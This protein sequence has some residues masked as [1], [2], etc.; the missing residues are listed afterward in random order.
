MR[1]LNLATHDYANFSHDNANA[2][3][4]V[5][6]D[7]VD[8]KRCPHEFNYKTES[9]IYTDDVF[10]DEIKKADIIQI[11]HSDENI[12]RIIRNRFFSK[13]TVVWH[14]GTAYRQG[15]KRLNGMFNDF[16]K[17]SFLA[18][19][20][21]GNLGAAKPVYSVGAIDT[22]KIQPVFN[23]KKEVGHFPSSV[24]NKGTANVVKLMQE[25]GIGFNVKTNRVSSEEQ[26]NRYNGIGIYVEMFNLMQ[27]NRPYGSWGIT[28]LEAACK[29]RVIITNEN[30]NMYKDTYGESALF[31]ANTEQ[32]FKEKMRLIMRSDILEL[33]KKTREWVV[34]NH[35][36]QATGERLKNILNGL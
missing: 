14:T 31:I 16:V 36:Y 11:M 24:E 6:V 23:G 28:A 2:L 7:C 34:K 13:K 4:S 32:E 20:E 27:N 18:L 21:F 3:R 15:F 19:G 1:V 10:F 22:E 26:L 30:N 29:G 25:L 8:L 33:Q 5:G 12:C 35:S 9:E 17:I